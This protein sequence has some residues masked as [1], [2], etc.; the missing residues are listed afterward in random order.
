M[1]RG[2]GWPMSADRRPKKIVAE[3]E[4]YCPDC[5]EEIGP[6]QTIYWSDHHDAYVCSVS[7]R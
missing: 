6:G 1:V 2:A 5:G 3:F 4:S 7:C